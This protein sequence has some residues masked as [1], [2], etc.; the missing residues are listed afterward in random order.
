[1]NPGADFVLRPGDTLVL[2]GT[3]AELD[4]TMTILEGRDGEEGQRAGWRVTGDE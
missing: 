2:V 4:R 1:M 3:H